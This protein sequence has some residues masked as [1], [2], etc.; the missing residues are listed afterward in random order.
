LGFVV[1]FGST[2]MAINLAGHVFH[3]TGNL[4]ATLILAAARCALIIWFLEHLFKDFSFVFRTLCYTLFFLGG[5][6]FL[7]LWDS[8]VK[9][10]KVG[11]PIYNWQDPSSM[12]VEH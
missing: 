7:S 8:E 5:M 9:P 12:K 11:D 3:F 4:I 2:P 1:D 10:G 6:I